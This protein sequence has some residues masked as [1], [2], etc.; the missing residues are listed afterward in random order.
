MTGAGLERFHGVEVALEDI[1]WD[2]EGARCACEH[3]TTPPR[4]H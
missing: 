4:D 3:K 1:G 2:L